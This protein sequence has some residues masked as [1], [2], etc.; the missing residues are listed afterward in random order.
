MV[1]AND[2]D[3]LHAAFQRVQSDLK[4]CRIVAGALVEGDEDDVDGGSAGGWINL[5]LMVEEVS[6]A[7]GWIHVSYI[8]H[9]TRFVAIQSTSRLADCGQGQTCLQPGLGC[10]RAVG[11]GQPG[12]FISAAL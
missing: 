2:V 5:Q 4:N 11:P 8:A 6:G 1:R 9:R 10:R 12:H 3:E 7:G